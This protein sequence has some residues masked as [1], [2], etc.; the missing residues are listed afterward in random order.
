MNVQY[1]IN[2]C[3]LIKFK[4]K[5]LLEET[6]LK[7]L[8]QLQHHRPSSFPSLI[9]IPTWIWKEWILFWEE[10]SWRPY[11]NLAFLLS[12]FFLWVIF[13]SIISPISSTLSSSKYCFMTNALFP[14]VSMSQ[15]L[16]VNDKMPSKFLHGKAKWPILLSQ[17]LLWWY[18]P[19]HNQN[20]SGPLPHPFI[21]YFCNLGIGI[22]HHGNKKIEE[23]D[24]QQWHKDEPMDFGYV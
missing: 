5:D 21:L 7:H 9:L 12:R 16:K 23:K 15:Y 13:I 2:L 3:C 10:V 18:G 1:K 17:S 6:H 20:S 22:S 11:P 19:F 4:H 24:N 14:W 8:V